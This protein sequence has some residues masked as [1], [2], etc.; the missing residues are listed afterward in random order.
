MHLSSLGIDPLI[1]GHVA[2]HI[3]TTRNTV[4]TAVY[5][6]NDYLVEKRQALVAWDAAMARILRGDDPLAAPS[7]VITLRA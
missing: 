4:T 5:V 6:R 7:N 1:I 2:N 3:S